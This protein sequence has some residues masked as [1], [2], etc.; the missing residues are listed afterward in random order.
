MSPLQNIVYGPVR[1]RRL[2]RSLGINLLPPGMKV[3][4]MNC[5]YCQYGWTRGAV[6]YRGQGVGW[7]TTQAVETAVTHRLT[8]AADQNERIDRLTVAC[9]G[10]PTLHPDFEEIAARLR[11]IRDRIVPSLRL[12]ILSNSTTAGS[13]DVRTGLASFD[14][15][16][17]KLDAGDAMTFANVNGG[18]RHLSD[19]ID[20]LR[21]LPAV[22]VQAM[23]VR[24]STGVIDN[25]TDAAVEAWV[26]ALE[27]IRAVRVQVYTLARSPALASLRPVPARRLREIAERVRAIGI[28]AEVFAERVAPA[29]R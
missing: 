16:Y 7:P 13:V 25:S 11:A 20:A 14:E 28:P 26:C 6:R 2:G 23:F 9:H 8:I 4:N 29:S 15:C 18:G 1:S 19:V 3:C 5:A 24:N 17:M 22:I 12:A 27:T 21:N 10:E